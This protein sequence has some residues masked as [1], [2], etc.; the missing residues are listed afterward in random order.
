[1]LDKNTNILHFLNYCRLY[2]FKI[3]TLLHAIFRRKNRRIALLKFLNGF[4]IAVLVLSY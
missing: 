4:G 2:I 1:M 3:C